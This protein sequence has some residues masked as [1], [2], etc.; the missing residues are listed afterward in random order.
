MSKYFLP[1]CPNCQ[2]ELFEVRQSPHSMLNAEQFDSQKA[3]D[4]YCASCK[5]DK[6]QTGYLYFWTKD[7]R[8]KADDFAGGQGVFPEKVRLT[9]GPLGGIML[10]REDDTPSKT[11]VAIDSNPDYD[12]DLNSV[13]M[14][15]DAYGRH[16][17]GANCID[18]TVCVCGLDEKRKKVLV[19]LNRLIKPNHK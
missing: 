13:K 1:H 11:Y 12:A 10:S 16:S 17:G 19:S 8:N 9:F 18:G 4:F 15:I 7:L 3:G 5:S 14:A 6:C 2:K